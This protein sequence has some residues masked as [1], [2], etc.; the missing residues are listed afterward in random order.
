MRYALLAD[1]HG[2]LEAFVAVL[3]DMGAQGGCDEILCLGDVVGYGP[4]PHECI[5]LLRQRQHVCVA[6]NHDWAAIGRIDTGD[7]N[8]HAAAAASWTSAHLDPGDAE[9]L[10][11]LPT[12]LV[13]DDLTLVHGSPRE[14]VWEYLFSPSDAAENLDYFDTRLCAVGHTHMPVLFRCPGEGGEYC[15]AEHLPL[16]ESMSL[17]GGRLI[18]NPGGVGQPRDGDPR[19]SYVIFDADAAVIVH[20]RVEYDIALTQAKMSRAGLPPPLI[21]RLSYGR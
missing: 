17:V 8:P 5:Q 9:Y 11:Q 19:A 1:I 2:N 16:G 20:R 13:R 15:V 7:F 12:R 4:D 3:G 6:G 14:P 10:G 18:V 21:L